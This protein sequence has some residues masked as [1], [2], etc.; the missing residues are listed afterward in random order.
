MTA[1]E[2]KTRLLVLVVLL[3]CLGSTAHAESAWIL[4]QKTTYHKVGASLATDEWSIIKGFPKFHSCDVFLSQKF[5]NLS[6]ESYREDDKHF[7]SSATEYWIRYLDKAKA[8]NENDQ[9]VN[10]KLLCLPETIDPR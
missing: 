2:L 1:T 5:Q 8:R 6:S 10:K 3:L 7:A 9:L 4:W